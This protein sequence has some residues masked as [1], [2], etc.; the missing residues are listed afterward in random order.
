MCEKE[1]RSG[2]RRH[3]RETHEARREERGAGRREGMG[4]KGKCE[5]ETRVRRWRRRRTE[6]EAME[7]VS[8]GQ[9]AVPVGDCCSRHSAAS[10][11]PHPWSPDRRYSWA[12]GDREWGRAVGVMIPLALGT[13]SAESG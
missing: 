7:R 9:S 2:A 3:T 5:S 1:L 8:A 12:G 6:K 10:P 11:R 13:R 4:V